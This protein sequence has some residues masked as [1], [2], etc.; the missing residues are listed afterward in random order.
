MFLSKRG[1]IWYLYY[2]DEDGKRRKVSTKCKHKPDALKFITQFKQKQKQQRAIRHNV[3]LSRFI[4][5]YLIYSKTEHRPKTT[6]DMEYILNEFKNTIGDKNLKQISVRDIELF[7]AKKRQVS[8]VTAQKNYVKLASAMSTAVRWQYL[9]SNPVK[10]VT[11]P[12]VSERRPVYI[13]KDE[14]KQLLGHITDNEL[15]DIVIVA[16]STGLRLNELLHLKWHN[17][18]LINK[19]IHVVNEDGFTTKSKKSRSVPMND[20]SYQVLAQRKESAVCELVFHNRMRVHNDMKISKAFKKAVRAC[21]LNDKICFHTL[22]H[23][24]CSWLVKSGVSIYEVMKLAGHSSVSVTQIYAHLE[25]E[26]RHESVNLIKID[27]EPDTVHK[28]NH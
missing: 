7:I 23:T 6:S 21:N 16:V 24:F 4:S 12:K 13:S 20:K 26:Q 17:V 10:K 22:R 9:E 11:K 19:V 3:K 14:M 8:D 5:E 27:A 15:R 1:K 28:E 2:T 25:P 18:D